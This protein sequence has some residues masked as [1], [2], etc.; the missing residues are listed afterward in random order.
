MSTKT[1]PEVSPD[2]P[3]A[4][5]W[6]DTTSA[7]RS[8]GFLL[9]LIA[10][11]GL[12]LALALISLGTNDIVTWLGF[13][14]S[15][16]EEGLV[17]RYGEIRVES[18][19]MNHPPLAAYY[20]FGVREIALALGLPFALLFKLPMIAAD[21]ATAALL[22]VIGGR[23]GRPS[24]VLTAAYVFSPIAIGISAY[25]G[26]TDCLCV[27]LAFLATL[28]LARGRH[29]AAGLALAASLNV[30]LI[31]ILLLPFLV[32]QCRNLASMRR[33]CVGF[34]CGLL[35]FLPFVLLQPTD[36][37]RATLVDGL[38][39]NHWG[40]TAFLHAA[41]QNLKLQPLVA[42]VIAG[43]LAYGTALLLCL[44]G[45][46]ALAGRVRPRWST[47]ELGAICFALFLVVA[48]S[49][50]VQY[51]IYVLPFLLLVDFTRG[52]TYS[53]VGGLF[54]LVIYAS[55]WTGTFPLFSRFS[56][57]FPMPAP[58]VGVLAWAVLVGYL[59]HAITKLHGGG[60]AAI[61]SAENTG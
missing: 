32:L 6:R 8:P 46:A 3:G 26:N 50:A 40:V 20:A 54:A 22:G 11:F 56:G 41:S 28:L 1:S 59:A 19:V 18:F 31:P 49:F 12:R 25:H 21:L 9:L 33:F 39:L 4:S 30:K 23:P 57:G 2:E 43:F 52:L 42:P 58:L 60:P 10:G 38:E 44:V 36:F 13:A 35:P 51:L 48:P 17:G 16:A 7:L 34:A 24:L 53:L 27:A 15:I 47:L 29:A 45:L 5:L 14:A 37:Y 55:F 61:R